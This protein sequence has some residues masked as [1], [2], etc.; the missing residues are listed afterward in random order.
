MNQEK[1]PGLDGSEPLGF[2]AGLGVMRIVSGRYPETTIR[3]E[4]AG[5]LWNPVIETE[6][7]T[8]KISL[9][10][11]SELLS[12]TLE[13]VAGSGLYGICSMGDKIG[14]E[15][16]VFREHAGRAVH[17]F[18]NHA[19]GAL[20]ERWRANLEA[21]LASAC[22]CDAITDDKGMIAPTSISFSNG[23]SGQ[24]LIKDFRNAALLC[25]PEKII[26][27]L[28]GNPAN[29]RI[30]SLNWDPR[31]QRAAALRWQD[32]ASEPSWVDPAANALAFIGMTYLTAVPSSDIKTTGW[33]YERPRG[34]V[35]PLWQHALVSDE[36]AMLLAHTLSP[37]KAV[38]TG[39]E[40]V[41]FSMAINPD[42][43]R[44][45]FAPS[46]SLVWNPLN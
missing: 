28:S 44:N 4:P 45:Y 7:A 1:L 26:A 41:R 25:K 16:I 39:I 33:K 8:F 24:L 27:S 23:A 46:R 38:Q 35:W 37:E 12:V 13:K 20:L 29:E 11:L 6:P 10:S 19:E 9:D 22:G 14:I 30:T 34:F 18:W 40:E 2:L 42:G 31:D 21:A 43:K 32:P 17:D 3:W 15:P 5:G 36:V